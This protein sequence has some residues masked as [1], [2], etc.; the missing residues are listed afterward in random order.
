MKKYRILVK[1]GF[2]GTIEAKDEEELYKKLST[3]AYGVLTRK[4]N[5]LFTRENIKEIIEEQELVQS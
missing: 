5:I 3:G 4:E 2:Y 1:Q